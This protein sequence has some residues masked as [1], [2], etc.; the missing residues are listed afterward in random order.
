MQVYQMSY[1][2]NN[3]YITKLQNINLLKKLFMIVTGFNQ[4]SQKSNKAKNVCTS[5]ILEGIRSEY[6]R[7]SNPIHIVELDI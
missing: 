5:Y 4:F 2:L 6:N 3:N 1:T 7:I